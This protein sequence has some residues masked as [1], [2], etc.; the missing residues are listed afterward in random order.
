MTWRSGGGPRH[1]AKVKWLEGHLKVSKIVKL[2]EHP[3]GTAFAGWRIMQLKDGTIQHTMADYI[4]NRQK[5]ISIT[6]KILKKNASQTA[7][8]ADEET[9]L[10]GAISSFCGSLGKDVQMWPLQPTFLSGRFPVP[11]PHHE[12]SRRD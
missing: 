3:G 11:E 5:A 4:A 8:T 6:R 10:R 2:R 1:R 7:R 9:Q 12:R